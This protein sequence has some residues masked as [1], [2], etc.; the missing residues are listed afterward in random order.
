M[1]INPLVGIWGNQFEHVIAEK[2]VKAVVFR[3]DILA[4]PVEHD[5]CSIT[6]S[7]LLCLPVWLGNVLVQVIFS[8]FYVFGPKY[9]VRVSQCPFPLI[10]WIGSKLF[11]SSV[12]SISW[13]NRFLVNNFRFLRGFSSS[14]CSGTS[15]YH[16]SNFLLHRS[17]QFQ[18]H[19][20]HFDFQKEDLINLPCHHS[21]QGQVYFEQHLRK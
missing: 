3:N 10:Y 16:L 2:E 13:T 11:L 5:I 19:H 12:E 7:H 4:A 8:V 1:F 21:Q 17:L 15:S 9:P 6:T 18:I 20:H 14:F